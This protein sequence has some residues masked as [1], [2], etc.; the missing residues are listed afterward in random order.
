MGFE[1]S[2]HHGDS[3]RGASSANRDRAFRKREAIRR[4]PAMVRCA[5]E[6]C[7]F[8]GARERRS[9]R[10]SLRRTTLRDSWPTHDN[11]L[12]RIRRSV[13]ETQG[14]LRD[15]LSCPPTIL[16][17]IH[18]PRHRGLESEARP[19]GSTR[20]PRRSNAKCHGMRRATCAIWVQVC[21]KRTHIGS[22]SKALDRAV[23]GFWPA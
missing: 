11:D 17:A 20:S 9:L 4:S 13:S 22:D 2:R 14:A 5:R 16:L 3:T 1:D 7:D 10:P 18:V 15:S 8:C 12:R 6:S 19:A 21:S 23:V